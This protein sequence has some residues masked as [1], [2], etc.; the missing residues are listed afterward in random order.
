MQDQHGH[1][2]LLNVSG[3]SGLQSD[4]SSLL[5]ASMLKPQS[6]LGGP[7]GSSSVAAYG[8]STSSDDPANSEEETNKQTGLV[9]YMIDPFTSP[10][11]NP[12]LRVPAIIGL[13]K[14]Y[15]E[16]LEHLPE[17]V[18][19]ITQLQLISL[20]SLICH[21][22]P[23][24]DISRLD[25]LKS[26]SMNVFARCK[27]VLTNQI[28]AKSLTGFGPAAAL[29]NFFKTKK[30]EL[31]ISRVFTP[32]FILAPTKDKQTELGE[33]FGDR[34]EKSSV[35]FCSYC[36]TEDQRWLLA[37]L[38]NDRGEMSESAVININISERTK[39]PKASIKRLALR[40]LMEFIISVMS[41]WMNPWRLI[42]GKLG[43]LGHGE[44]KEWANLL[45]KTSLLNYSRHL[46]TKCGQC[47]ILPATETVS[48]LSACLVS[49]E[50]DSKLRVM[51]DQ[52]TNDDRLASFNKC[53]LST[54][55]DA[56]A[57]H[58]LVFPTSASIQSTQGIVGED[59]LVGSGLDDDLLNQFP[60]DD[61][62][63]DLGVEGG[64]DDLFGTW[65]DDN[66]AD[67]GGLASH[68][69]DGTMMSSSNMMGATG[70]LGLTGDS[71]HGAHGQ[72]GHML[73]QTAQLLQQPLALGYYIS[74]AKL[75]PMP[76]WFW[77]TS[78]HLR[79]ASPVFL[80]SAL[81][82]HMPCVQLSD[83]LLHSSV[84]MG[85]KSHQLDSNLTTDVLRYVLEGYNSLSWLALHSKTYDRQSCLPVHM[86]NLLQLY[87]MMESFS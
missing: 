48:I 84:G 22:R 7:G 31:C 62:I 10:S 12:N 45:S 23:I 30:A 74:T 5:N 49:L 16:L 58:I 33:M 15:T 20:D 24:A 71:M 81:H 13:I 86:Q 72:H 78:S 63:E 14:C 60:L 87:Y 21:S 65:P 39:R 83:D 40:K 9:I 53:P 29:E 75:G 67:I 27:R 11:L 77:S 82:I 54:P 68:H 4:G 2:S 17:H 3:A 1:G 25:Q 6:L 64:M 41:E 70:S 34:R 85:K 56:S 8:P 26:L 79:N 69:G 52:F 44:L 19:R 51:P 46:V 35:L 28:T 36:I 32:P 43:R 37:S 57:T 76:N 59:P 50:P 38:T 73:D 42:I 18:R 80:K 55:E 61:G 47:N 66:Q